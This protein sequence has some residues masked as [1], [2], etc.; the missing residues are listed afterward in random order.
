MYFRLFSTLIIIAVV[1]ILFGKSC[2][3]S[4]YSPDLPPYLLTDSPWADSLIQCM[5]LDEKIGQLFMVAANGKNTDE[6]YYVMIDSLI[7]NY[8]LGG[9]IY[10]Q[11]DP[12]EHN[13]L[14]NRYQSKSS[15]PL[16]NGMDGEWGLQCVLIL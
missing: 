1:S 5:S 3:N 14:V 7:E 15:I 10:F 9:L 2:S 11:A 13:R 12:N 6:N 16:M 8:A 4:L